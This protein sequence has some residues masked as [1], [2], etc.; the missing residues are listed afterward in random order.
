MEKRKPC[1]LS[2]QWRVERVKRPKV[3]EKSYL[4]YGQY[5][6]ERQKRRKSEVFLSRPNQPS[7]QLHS[8]CRE[9]DSVKEKYII[10][11]SR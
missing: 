10:S 8:N 1:L 2:S 7:R 9:L 6:K 11:L 5:P 3:T 4:G